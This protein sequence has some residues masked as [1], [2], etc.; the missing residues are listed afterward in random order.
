MRKKLTRHVLLFAGYGV[1]G[2]LLAAVAGAV[3]LLEARPALEPWH[4]LTLEREFSAAMTLESFADYLVLES[5]LFEELDDRIVD[6]VESGPE[7]LVNRYARGSLAA[8]DRWDRD[9]NR[10][11]ELDVEQPVAGALMLHGMSDSPY[12]MRA[13]AERLRSRGVQVLALRYPGHGTAPA[14]LTTST[15]EDL[16]AAVQLAARH[17]SAKLDGRPL[18]L[19]GYSTGGPLAVDL[20]VRGL[21]DESLP[22]VAGLILFSPAMGITS[23]AALSP[24]QARLGRVLGFQKMAW[25]SLSPEYDP[26]KYRSFPVNAA[27]QVWR[28]SNH[29][30]QQLAG[31]ERA[32]R[33]DAIPPV[34]SFQSVVDDTIDVSALR[35]TLYDRLPPGAGHGV[36]VYD[37]NRRAGMEPLLAAD[38]GPVLNQ[39]LVDRERHFDLTVVTNQS[40]TSE[41]VV[42]KSGRAGRGVEAVCVLDERWPAGVYSMTHIALVFPPDDPLY[43]GPDA[44]PYSG[45]KLGKVVL[46]GEGSALRISPAGFLRQTWNPFFEEQLHELL[47]FMGLEEPRP[48]RGAQ[49]DSL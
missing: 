9:W 15:W 1:V 47:E 5:A 43:G 24:W 45:I 40:P 21:D 35:R 2:A 26:F 6:S 18:Y 46:R 25:N 13:L 41:L 48:C 27:V 11:F 17:L 44:T 20:V 42:R 38:P 12:S 32:G 33:M 8:P 39:M 10:S 19:F 29:V 14:S 37:L 31:L 36:F 49:A 3:V 16:A 4:E 23:L 34:L 30:E 28:L 7:T 22:E